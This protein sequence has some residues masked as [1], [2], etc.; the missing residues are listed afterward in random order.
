MDTH[1][2]TAGGQ[3]AVD[4]SRFRMLHTMLRVQD[5]ERSLDFY[6]RLLGMNLLRKKDSRLASS[7]WPSSAMATK[8][9][10]AWSS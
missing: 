7:R 3:A 8:R 4:S 1:E 10:T 2:G 9:R 5:L 6:T